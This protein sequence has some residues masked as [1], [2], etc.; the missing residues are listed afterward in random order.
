MQPGCLVATN[1]SRHADIV[2]RTISAI[3]DLRAAGKKISFYAVA[4]RAQVSRSTLYRS[5]D[6]RELVEAARADGML[7][8]QAQ[9]E[10]LDARIAELEDE[11]SRVSLERDELERAV[12]S[13]SPVR[14]AFVQAAEAA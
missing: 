14:Y 13:I 7:S 8:Q 2:N 5:E 12:R 9:H 10:A 6:L 1:N 4:E 3:E 11:L